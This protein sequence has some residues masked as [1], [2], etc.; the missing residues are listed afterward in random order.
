MVEINTL[1]AGN[2]RKFSLSPAP[3]GIVAM[4]EDVTIFSNFNRATF[5]HPAGSKS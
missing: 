4:E 1:L 5:D 2:I 3:T